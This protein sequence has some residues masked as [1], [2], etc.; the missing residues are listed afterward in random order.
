MSHYRY[1]SSRP[2]HWI[3]PRPYS[4]PCLRA[5]AYGPVRPLREP[6]LLERLLGMK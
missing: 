2:H 1:T 4:D 5:L 6:T 3:S